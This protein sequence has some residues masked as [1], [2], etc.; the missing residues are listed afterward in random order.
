MG[1]PE[2][3]A[4]GTMMSPVWKLCWGT[5]WE[6]LLLLPSER[7]GKGFGLPGHLGAR[8]EKEG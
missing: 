6:L 1:N 3:E 7:A 5:P 2:L 4:K 8:K